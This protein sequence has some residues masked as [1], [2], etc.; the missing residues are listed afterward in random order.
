MRARIVLLAGQ[1]VSNSNIARQV[2]ATLKTVGKWRQ[3]FLDIGIDGLLDEP[4]PG[5]SRKLS[6]KQVER[7]L[8]RTLESQPE[9]ATHWS[10]RD[11]AKACGLSQSQHQPHLAR[12]FSGSASLRD[13]Q[14]FPRSAVHRQGAR[15][16]GPVS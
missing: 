6:D 10:T 11:M 9:A 5:T 8:A 2:P 15:H 3:R 7:V 4:R 16:R 13:L 14:A 1:G 12:L